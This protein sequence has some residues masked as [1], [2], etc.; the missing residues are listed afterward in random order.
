MS[1]HVAFHRA[2]DTFRMV[3]LSGR[4]DVDS[5]E[6]VTSQALTPLEISTYTAMS[7]P[8][9]SETAV[10]VGVRVQLYKLGLGSYAGQTVDSDAAATASRSLES[11]KVM[12][13]G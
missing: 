1:L 3:T 10:S 8:D 4:N 7:L 5:E 13:L 2:A 9:V 6:S 12:K 11:A